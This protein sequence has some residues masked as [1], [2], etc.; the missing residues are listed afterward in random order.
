MLFC[1]TWGH[2]NHLCWW[3][4]ILLIIFGGRGELS[5]WFL[6]GETYFPY[7]SLLNCGLGD[8]RPSTSEKGFRSWESLCLF[9]TLLN[10]ATLEDRGDSCNLDFRKKQRDH[11]QDR[12]KITSPRSEN[13]EIIEE[14]CEIVW[15]KNGEIS[16]CQRML[17][18]LR[19]HSHVRQKMRSRDF[20]LFFFN[21]SPPQDDQ[22]NVGR[23]F[24]L[25]FNN[26]LK[27][28]YPKL[29]TT[30]LS[31]ITIFLQLA[32]VEDHEDHSSWIKRQQSNFFYVYE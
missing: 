21:L 27:L 25:I 17:V 12:L 26:I 31:H 1:W 29:K 22:L 2:M 20:L 19:E 13:E 4:F 6:R 15:K 10:I 7:S 11:L 23:R 24:F 8:L 14:R 28:P 9:A 30:F 16:I 32:V 5:G 3:I 18:A